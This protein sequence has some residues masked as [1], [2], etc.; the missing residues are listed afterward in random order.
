[1]KIL[2]DCAL[3]SAL[4]IP[5]CFVDGDVMACSLHLE[6]SSTG[7]NKRHK[8]QG[9]SQGAITSSVRRMGKTLRYDTPSDYSRRARAEIDTRADT[10]CAGCTFVLYETTGKVVDVS[11]FHDVL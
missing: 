3:M 5:K 9:Q 8:T 1:V 10:V 2:Y 6:N 4:Y 11:G 7:R